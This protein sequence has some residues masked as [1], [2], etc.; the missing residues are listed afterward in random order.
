MD[1]KLS[2]KTTIF[3]FFIVLAVISILPASALAND[4]YAEDHEASFAVT[5]EGSH[6][7]NPDDSI[8]SKDT[9]L[10]NKTIDY[11]LYIEKNAT[12]TLEGTTTVNGDVYVFGT[13]N[14]SGN[15]TISGTLYGLHYGSMFSA[16]DYDYGY[17]NGSGNLKSTTM[18]IKNTFL[19]VKASDILPSLVIVN[20]YKATCTSNGLTDG[21]KCSQCG[22]VIV[23]QKVISALGHNWEG[24]SYSWSNG[25][26][27]VT[28]SRKCR[29]DTSHIELETVDAVATITKSASY[30]E[31]G[32]TTYSAVFTNKAFAKQLK[33]LVDIPKLPLKAN[34]MKVKVK[35][36]SIKS[37]KIRKKAQSFAAKKIFMVSN[38]KGKVAYKK[39]SGNEKISVSSK[40]KITVK[41]GLKKG[42]YRI[43]VKVS[44]AGS[45]EYKA[46][47][48]TITVIIKIK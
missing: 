23:A 27:T 48:K 20:G 5:E 10:S 40:G 9:V 44:A 30:T 1:N 17:I 38:A 6:R 21:K 33:T 4:F 25:N 41:K 43:R 34:T 22:E 15:L 32:Q 11:D 16:G 39:L 3:F 2:V 19:D 37:S 36:A 12:L 45:I 35:S 29:N 14:Y 18:V 24:A 8:I 28:A 31:M 42:T 46:S 13:L 7:H 26:K 47:N